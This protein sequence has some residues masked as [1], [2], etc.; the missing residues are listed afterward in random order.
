MWLVIEGAGVVCASLTYVIVLTVQVGMIRI[1]VWE[2]LVKGDLSS[3]ANLVIFQYHCI[4]IYWCHFKC[5]TTEPGVLPKNYDT[6]SFKKIAPGLKDA[7]MGVKAE[8]SN[9]Q[10]DHAG[11]K[12][13]IEAIDKRI[14]EQIKNIDNMN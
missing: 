8:V 2:G 5:M 7:I 9:M 11:Q 3:I 13:K 10:V 6:L 4:M 14:S 1:G 12:E